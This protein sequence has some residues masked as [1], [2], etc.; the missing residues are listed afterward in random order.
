VSAFPVVLFGEAVTALVV[1]GGRVGTRKALALLE[2]GATVRVVAPVLSAEL[3][4]AAATPRL[5]L[6]E[7][8]F[9]PADIADA[10]IVIA[11]TNDRAV[12]AA[13]AAAARDGGRLANVA[14]V[15]G[16][17]SFATVAAHRAGDLVVAVFTGG[18]PTAAVRIRDAI[19]RRFDARYARALDRLAALRTRLLAEGE[20]ARW[21]RAADALVP[22]DFCDAVEGGTFDARAAEW[23]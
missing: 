3:R 4:R 13:A 23:R 6:H 1:G 19:A 10:Q 15:P 5:E 9:E 21:R 11:A 17:G 14:D 18:V 12:N 20:S 2:S 16:E 8:A 22:A 7:R